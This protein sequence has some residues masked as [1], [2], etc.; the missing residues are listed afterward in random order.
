MTFLE[1]KIPMYFSSI[2]AGFA[3][4]GLLFVPNVSGML[5]PVASILMTMSVILILLF[6]AAIILKGLFSLFSSFI[7][8]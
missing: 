8:Q 3:V 5:G 4:I 1:S 6:A 2:L 7:K